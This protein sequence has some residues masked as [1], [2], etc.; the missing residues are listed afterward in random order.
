[1]DQVGAPIFDYED[2]TCSWMTDIH[3]TTIIQNL[4]TTNGEI[5]KEVKR[6]MNIK[7]EFNHLLNDSFDKDLEK[8]DELKSHMKLIDES[9]GIINQVM[10]SF[11]SQQK[12]VI[13]LETQYKA[14]LGKTKEDIQKLDTFIQFL[15]KIND[16]YQ[17]E[18]IESIEKSLFD[19]CK[20]I[21]KDNH[22]DKM[23]RE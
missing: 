19:L 16:K 7:Q 23:K 12:K 13:E 17:K 10:E 5:P 20:K 18:E 21:E 2:S 11:Q 4:S 14:E 22:C 9:Q 6:I 1:M 3:P 8:S 15:N